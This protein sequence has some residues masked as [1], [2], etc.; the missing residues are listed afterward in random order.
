MSLFAVLAEKPRST[1]ISEILMDVSIPIT[2]SMTAP[3][4]GAFNTPIVVKLPMMAGVPVLLAKP[5]QL[6]LE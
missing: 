4:P 1:F 6:P 3:L 2:G 5:S